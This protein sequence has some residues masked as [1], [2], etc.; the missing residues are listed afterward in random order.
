MPELL[1]DEVFYAQLPSVHLASGALLR[2]QSNRCLIVN[3]TYREDWLIP[4]GCVDEAE[5]P[6]ETCQR[7]VEEEIG[8]SLE[9]GSLLSVEYVA[10]HGPKGE[11]VHFIFDGGILS[12]EQ[13]DSIRLQTEEISE[14]R[15]L[16]LEEACELLDPLLAVRYRAAWRALESGICYLERGTPQTPS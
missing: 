10:R 7:E 14:F 6:F 9:I 8:L 11:S 12:P 3:P 5:S 1:P 13:I 2:D 4:G 15:L 16:P